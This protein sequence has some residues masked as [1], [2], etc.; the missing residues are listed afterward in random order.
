D[1][2]TARDNFQQAYKLDPNN[3]FTVNNM[4][5]L[6]ELEGDKET[7][8]SY[9]EQARHAKR[10][11]A[12]IVVSRWPE[13]EGHQVGQ[14]A[15]HSTALVESSFAAQAEAKRRS[16]GPPASRRRGNRIV[17]EPKT[18]FKPSTGFTPPEYRQPPQ[19]NNKEP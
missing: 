3:S 12:K 17:V 2:K 9:Y 1:R 18:P 16:G 13:V 7:A 4:G 11:N 15:E 14:I 8:Q 5:Y 19:N 6:A 10:S